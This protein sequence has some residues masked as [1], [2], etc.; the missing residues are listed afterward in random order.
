MNVVLFALTAMIST[1]A[2][3]L[4]ALRF[5]DHMHPNSGTPGRR[6]S[7]GDVVNQLLEIEPAKRN[8]GAK[9]AARVH[10]A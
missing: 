10:P 3:G 5:R 8:A 9:A 2:G 1:A 4:F 7:V 6:Q